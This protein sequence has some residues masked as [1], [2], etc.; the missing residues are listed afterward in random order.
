MTKLKRNFKYIR[1]ATTAD[2]RDF[3]K[4]A[5]EERNFSIADGRPE[6]YWRVIK[7]DHYMLQVHLQDFWGQDDLTDPEQWVTVGDLVRCPR[8][9]EMQVYEVPEDDEMLEH[10]NRCWQCH[11]EGVETI[12][13]EEYV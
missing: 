8:C 13:R 7:S 3:E 11:T 1:R 5:Q 12:L 6:E 10:L 2:K 4:V 9:G